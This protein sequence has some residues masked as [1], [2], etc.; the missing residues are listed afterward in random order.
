MKRKIALLFAALVLMLGASSIAKA[1]GLVVK[2]GI[3][4]STMGI[5]EINSTAVKNYTGWHAGLGYQTGSL[6]GFS[7][8]PELLYNSKGFVYGDTKLRMNYLEVPIN[9]QW[10]IDLI[11]AKPFIM[12][13]PILGVN[14]NNVPSNESIP[15]AIMDGIRRTE[16]GLGIGAGIDIWKIQITARYNWSF[17]N[18]DW[19][20]INIDKHTPGCLEISFGLRF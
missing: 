7:L 17:G 10:G 9:I 4:T 2:A 3:S 8:Q 11:V 19:E 15:D 1:E 18:F 6:L 16:A 13:T 5:S 12:V 14:L 20:S